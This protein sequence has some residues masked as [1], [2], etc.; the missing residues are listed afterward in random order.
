MIKDTLESPLRQKRP[1]P[2]NDFYESMMCLICSDFYKPPIIQ[3][4]KGHSYC[5]SCVQRM[6]ECSSQS[7]ACAICRSPISNDLRNYSLE[8]VLDKFTVQ[9]TWISRGCKQDITLTDR[10]EHEKTCDYRPQVNCYY[11]DLQNCN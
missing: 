6:K 5:Y 2:S 1:R 4:N 10:Y 3:C 7:K 8:Q 11:K 9:C